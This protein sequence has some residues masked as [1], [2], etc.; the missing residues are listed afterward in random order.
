MDTGD[1]QSASDLQHR[2]GV[3]SEDECGDL[4]ESLIDDETAEYEMMHFAE[5]LSET[6]A[7]VEGD[8]ERR[9]MV[10]IGTDSREAMDSKAYPQNHIGKI[11]A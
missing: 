6:L 8:D 2:D 10:V 3:V 11:V 9:R 7:D 1:P 5:I 4:Y